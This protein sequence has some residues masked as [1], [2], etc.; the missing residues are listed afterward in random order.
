[1]SENEKSKIVLAAVETCPPDGFCG[2]ARKPAWK[3]ETAAKML[4]VSVPTVRNWVLKAKA[5]EGCIPFY[6]KSEGSK[7]FFPIRELV[8]WDTK[9]VR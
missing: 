3:I 2:I 9:G 4:G 7:I 1:M 6:Q 8:E 5:G